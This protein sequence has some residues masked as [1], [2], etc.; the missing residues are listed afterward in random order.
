M[1]NDTNEREFVGNHILV[2]RK[3]RVLQ[4]VRHTHRDREEEEEEDREMKGMGRI[5]TSVR[6]KTRDGD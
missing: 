1:K 4:I 2:C 3:K 6:V 5:N